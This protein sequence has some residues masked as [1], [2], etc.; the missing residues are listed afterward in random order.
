MSRCARKKSSTGIYHL[1]LKGINA[2][3]IFHDDEDNQRF[4]KTLKEYK[5]VCG[6]ELYAYCLMGNHVHLL[7][8]ESN[9]PL[10]NIIKRIASSYVYWYNLKYQRQGH[11]FQDRFRS[12]PVEN[13]A[14][15]M[16]A[17]RYIHQNPIK[18][19][20]AKTLESYRYSSYHEYLKSE[21][22]I[23]KE[24]LFGMMNSSDFK[25]F[26]AE[27]TAAE[28]LD[29]RE[30]AF[31]VTDKDAL[32]IIVRIAHC[33]NSSEFQALSAITQKECI[34]QFKKKGLSIRQIS[35][36]LGVPKGIVERA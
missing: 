16:T 31:R 3:Q 25:Q 14:Y 26:C 1:M 10:E 18:A 22:I 28:C 4:L 9:E 5:T 6:Y 8:K 23:D 11:L 27:D 17:I 20:L 2:Q 19:G 7:L 29:V 30:K 24:L 35:R 12:E 15:F 32:Q 33:Q 36:L 34:V 21:T 13:D